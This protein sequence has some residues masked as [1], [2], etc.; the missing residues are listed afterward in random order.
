MFD[1]FFVRALI[2]GIGVAI[3]AGPFGCF[4]I[5]RRMAYFGDTMAH[6]ALL[7]ITLSLILEL[8]T[9]IG[10]FFITSA[11]ALALVFLQAR[12]DLPSDTILGILS[13]STLAAGLIVIG[14][15]TK[16]RVDMMAYLFGDVL[17]VD[18]QDLWFIWV[19]GALALGFLILI[20]RPL[21]AGTVNEELASAEGQRPQLARLI[22]LIL[23]AA[24]IAI[25]IKIVGIL[26]ITALLVIPPASAR[27]FAGNPEIMAILAA[28]LGSIAVIFGLSASMQWDTPAGPA[29]VVAA[30]L[31]FLISLLVPLPK[32]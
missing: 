17:A 4:V 16:N 19:G 2:A 10:V 11:L 6:S 5:W 9:S 25:A 32:R 1:D 14:L 3:L 27:R 18:R 13:H 31:L 26:L 22:F 29:I 30:L 7:G 21:L 15:M 12:A 24:V 23:L 8:N 20:W 28:A